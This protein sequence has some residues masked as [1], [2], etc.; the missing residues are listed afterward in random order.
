MS[1]TSCRSE[2]IAFTATL[3]VIA[4]D[5]GQTNW[6][7]TFVAHEAPPTPVPVDFQPKHP[8]PGVS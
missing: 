1:R 8:A 6:I 5:S 4:G 3:A 2:A 7:P